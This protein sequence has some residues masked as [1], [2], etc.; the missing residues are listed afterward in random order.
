MASTADVV[1]G[2]H[3]ELDMGDDWMPGQLAEPVI[4]GPSTDEQAPARPTATPRLR[5]G[6]RLVAGAVLIALAA[7]FRVAI[8]PSLL[9][10][11]T[12]YLDGDDR[13]LHARARERLDS[14]GRRSFPVP[15]RLQQE[16]GS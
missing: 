5:R 3:P 14:P 2:A 1:E 16:W 10:L 12:N 6:R 4:A 11:P 13:L 15:R 9:K 8:A 7:I